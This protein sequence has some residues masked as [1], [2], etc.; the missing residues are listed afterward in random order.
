[1]EH[2]GIR[3][4][5]HQL[6]L[7]R[8]Y[9]VEP[10]GD[11]VAVRRHRIARLDGATGEPRRKRAR[12][13]IGGTSDAV[14]V[15]LAHVRPHHRHRLVRLGEELEARKGLETGEF[16]GRQRSHFERMDDIGRQFTDLRA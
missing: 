1:M 11:L 10:P 2:I 3:P 5:R 8:G 7:R 9:S 4:E 14:T 13:A 16:V 12:E 15:F 6:Q